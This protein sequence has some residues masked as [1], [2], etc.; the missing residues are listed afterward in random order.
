MRRYAEVKTANMLMAVELSRR[1]KGQLRSYSLHPGMV[2]TNTVD[3]E[4]LWPAFR[5]LDI[6]TSDMKPKEN[7]FER[8]KTI[9]QGATTTVVAAFDPRLDDKAGTYLVDG[10]IAMKEQVASHAVDP[11]CCLLLE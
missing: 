10:N 2:A 9:P 6:V 8:W 11:V 1:S 7:G 3:K 5:Q 4:A